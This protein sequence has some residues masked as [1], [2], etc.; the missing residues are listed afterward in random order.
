[1]NTTL[2][3]SDVTFRVSVT[4]YDDFATLNFINFKDGEIAGQA[5]MYISPAT[6]QNLRE[7]LVA[8]VISDEYADFR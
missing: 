3:C 2:F 1:M 8:S 4:E 6:L 7:A 5:M